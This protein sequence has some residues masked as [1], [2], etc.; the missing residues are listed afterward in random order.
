MALFVN[1]RYHPLVKVAP[2]VIVCGCDLIFSIICLPLLLSRMW[3]HYFLITIDLSLNLFGQAILTKRLMSEQTA[4]KM[5]EVGNK[6]VPQYE[7]LETIL[8]FILKDSRHRVTHIDE[9]LDDV[10]WEVRRLEV[11]TRLQRTSLRL[12]IQDDIVFILSYDAHRPK[13]IIEGHGKMM[14]KGIQGRWRIIP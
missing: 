14:T 5:E 4:S 8:P 2:L 3:E 6:W 11:S 13:N 12:V 9:G 7:I 10:E 1:L